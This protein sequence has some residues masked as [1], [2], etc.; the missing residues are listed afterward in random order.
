MNLTYQWYRG[1]TEIPGATGASYTLASPQVAT[2]NGAQFH[3]VVTN[4]LGSVTSQTV[5][6]RVVPAIIPL[7]ISTQPATKTVL[8]GIDTTL[9]VVADG[10]GTLLYQWMKD[11]ADIPGATSSTLSFSPAVLADTG[12]YS[13]RVTDDFGTITSASASVLN[14]SVIDAWTNLVVSKGTT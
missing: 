6:L 4:P 3:V 10:T 14:T 9:T 12:V 11:G 5:T 8:D 7:A 1:T 2:D 13:V